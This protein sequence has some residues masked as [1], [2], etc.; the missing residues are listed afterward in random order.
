MLFLTKTQ[1]KKTKLKELL[2]D[3]AAQRPQTAN[4]GKVIKRVSKYLLEHK[5]TVLFCL[6][7]ML[8]SNLLALAAPK[9]SQK[10]QVK[11]T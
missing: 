5:L 9:L 6:A 1:K 10:A 11:I 4:K 7:I 2:A 8:T 3:S